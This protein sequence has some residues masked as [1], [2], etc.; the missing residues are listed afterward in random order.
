MLGHHVVLQLLFLLELVVALSESALLHILPHRL[1][2]MPAVS[3]GVVRAAGQALCDEVPTVPELRHAVCD[4]GILSRA[5]ADAV[6]LAA[7]AAVA[8][9]WRV[10]VPVGEHGR[11]QHGRVGQRREVVRGE[12]R[13]A[14]PDVGAAALGAV[15][16]HV[17]AL[18]G[19]VV[20]PDPHLRGRAP[21]ARAW[22]IHHL[23]M[24][25]I[26]G[27][28]LPAVASLRLAARPFPAEVEGLAVDADPIL[29][30][31]PPVADRVI[32]PA[33]H[34]RCDDPPAAAVICD[35]VEDVR[36]LL[37]RPL[38]ARPL[39]LRIS[40]LAADVPLLGSAATLTLVLL[41]AGAQRLP[42][43]LL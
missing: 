11:H 8:V 43:H 2:P 6:G 5:P 29:K 9:T 30:T 37:Q 19:V 20:P 13:G 26:L 39:V 10:H 40:L 1:E 32:G 17:P 42:H 22:H 15:Q 38:P 23:H 28:S 7:F 31:V 35:R 41:G 4:D 12:R 16:A 25:R 24:G 27:L 34:R 33:M 21:I 3:N 18:A 36:V 14:H